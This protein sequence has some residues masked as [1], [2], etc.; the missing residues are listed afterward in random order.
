VLSGPGF[1]AA[2]VESSGD[3]II[4]KD[5]V[6]TIL[7]WNHGA[8]QIFGY[9]ADEVIGKNIRILFPPE[10]LA[11]EA[12]IA[13][14]IRHGTRIE[15]HESVR[16]R[17]DGTDFPV[18]LTVSPIRN[19]QGV[20][21]GG[22]KILRDVSARVASE[23]ALE[24]SEA[25]FRASFEGAAVGK[26]M[27]EPQ[28]R[29]ILR[30]NRAL[31][32]MLGYDDAR[33]LVGQT[34]ADLTW[35]EDRAP[36]LFEYTRLLTGLSDAQ[37]G[38]KRFRR[39][40]GT[41][42]WV[43]VSATLA[44]VPENPLPIFAIIAIEDIDARY[45]AQAELLEAKTDLERVVVERTAAL[46]DRNL[47]LREVYHRVKN[48]LQV[49]DGLI[50]MQAHKLEDGAAKRGLA[51]LRGRIFALGLVHQQLM[52]SGDLKTFDVAPFLDELSKNILEGGAD[53]NIELSVETFPLQIGLDFAVPL[54]LL[55]TELVTN[56]LKHAF[57][58]RPGKVTVMLKT[59]GAGKIILSVSDNGRG[60]GGRS[61][62]APVRGGL[63]A[64][65]VKSLVAQLEGTMAISYEGGT[66][67]QI[68]LN[69][70]EPS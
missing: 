67:T 21:V 63:G 46:A 40:D 36:D 55:V 39:Q 49:V 62:I 43:R 17:K 41:P 58:G 32:R 51:S 69:V 54:G 15:H 33:A 50:V 14:S 52:G 28:S 64:G 25:E 68:A 3:A 35:G 1:L 37:L 2:I 70:P 6:G 22:S 13:E 26:I 30:A 57:A 18:S 65:I 42:L 45:K 48:N 10:R 19:A 16:R 38:E 60:L 20:I 44:R 66:T 29:R 7:S 27:A 8:E 31:V 11:E 23:R 5:L 12:L 34:L 61:D 9:A 53:D 59:D 4:G 47:L 56:S 24:F